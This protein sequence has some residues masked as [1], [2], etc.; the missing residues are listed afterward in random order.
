MEVQSKEYRFLLPKSPQETWDQFFLRRNYICYGIDR[1]PCMI[2]RLEE[3]I[4]YSHYWIAF[5]YMNC[6]YTKGIEKKLD[7]WFGHAEKTIRA[8]S[9]R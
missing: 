3:I 2:R 6:R 8:T 9:L 1:F 7:L 4:L 5:R